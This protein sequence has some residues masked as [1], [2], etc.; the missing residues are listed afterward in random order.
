MLF[1]EH[2]SWEMDVIPKFIRWP[3]VKKQEER[4]IHVVE[5]LPLKGI[6][7]LW[8]LLEG[9][10]CSQENLLQVYLAS[11]SLFETP[12]IHLLWKL[13]TLTEIANTTKK[14]RQKPI[15]TATETPTIPGPKP[16]EASKYSF[17]VP[18]NPAPTILVS[19]SPSW[20]EIIPR[21]VHETGQ[22]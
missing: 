19:T 13:R 21:S 9:L 7:K 8:V 17:T 16:R 15:R 20:E 18:S 4:Y 11:F 2:I 5:L 12:L 1:D 6:S 14:R 3:E 10:L 22:M